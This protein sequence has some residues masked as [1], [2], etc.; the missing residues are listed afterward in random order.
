MITGS[1]QK[2]KGLYYAVLNLYDDYGKRK[3]KWI[4]TGYTIKGNK[5]KAEEKLEQ[6]KIEYEQKSKIQLRNP[7]IYDKYKNILFCDYM[8]EWLEKQ[9]GKV[10]QT[11]YI[12]YEQ[13][14]KGRLYKYF[15]TKKIKLVD[16]K[17]KHIQ[18]FFDLLFAEGLSGNTVKHYRAN[19][20]KA[21]KSAVITEI[22]DSNPATKLESI[23]TKEYTADYYT[24]DELL[25]L[26]GIIKTTP[27]ELPVVIAGVYGLRREEVIGIKWNAIDFKAKTLTIRHTVCRGKIDGV[28]QFI[29]KDRAKS[30]S[31]YRTLPLFDF[32]ADLLN[33]YKDKYAEYK[34]FY[35][36]T[37]CNDY[38]DYICLM[39]N[40][41]L[42]KPG[43]VTQTFSKVLDSNNLRHIRL[44]DLRHSCGTLLIQNGV[45][46]KDIQ[47]W[48]G[49]S[50]FQTTLRYAHADIENKRIS[51]SVISDKLALDIKDTKKEQI[52]ELA[53]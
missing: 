27:I 3:P 14:I 8:L 45:P 28:T 11:T 4:P 37:Y 31:G 38:K 12:G 42:M 48:L 7:N 15:K 46:F 34:K 10:E 30:D 47:K 20:S 25:E 18:D 6:F 1:L 41:E 51:A 29:F 26:I 44:H 40:G 32:I 2:K 39:E 22:I 50:N 43:Y 21:L 35:G 13:V 23:K 36:N 53:I 24:Q 17:P 16:L 5:K 19:I 9:K 33:T 52:T 49:H